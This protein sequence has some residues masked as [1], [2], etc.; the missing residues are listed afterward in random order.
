MK[1]WNAILPPLNVNSQTLSGIQDRGAAG[2]RKRLSAACLMTLMFLCLNALTLSVDA[3]EPA[4]LNAEQSFT[5]FVTADPQINIPKWGTAGTE[6]MIEIMNQTPGESWP[7]GG[8]VA[9][10][11]G[12]LVLGDLVDDH[13]PDNWARY[14]QFFSPDG[15]QA[16]CRFPAFEIIGNHDLSSHQPAGEFNDLQKEFVRR[17]QQRPEKLN[18]GPQGYHYSWDWEEFHF[19][20]LNLFP[21]NAPRPVYDR[22]APWNDPQHSLD[23]LQTDLKN[24]VGDSGRPV[25]LM[26]HY[27]LEGWG[28]DKWWTPEDLVALKKAIKP[29]NV[30][31]IL[32]GH[33][34][35]YRRYQWDD[36]DVMMSPSPQADRKPGDENVESK[37]KGF[38]VIRV[39]KN[40]I[41]TAERTATGWKNQW[42]KPYELAA[43]TVTQ[44][45]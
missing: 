17:N 44:G 14:K 3:D 19:V 31:L 33:E 34:H 24:Q 12:L 36:Y 28:L 42:S 37:P 10:P 30:V 22:D 27:G 35:A 25:I 32:H 7:F 13:H 21:G 4:A 9:E 23:F 26:W 43:P 45:P 15:K 8:L 40:E 29:Y 2:Y 5:F 20:N 11:R 1:F 16:R 38:L 39:T 6:Q 41:Q 18:Y